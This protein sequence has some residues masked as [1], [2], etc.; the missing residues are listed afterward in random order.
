MNKLLAIVLVFLIPCFFIFGQDTTQQSSESAA[1]QNTT[2]PEALQ[3]PDWVDEAIKHGITR[4]KVICK[5]K[6]GFLKTVLGTVDTP[7]IR[8]AKAANEAKRKMMTFTRKDVTKEMLESVVWVYFKWP[9]NEMDQPSAEHVVIKKIKSKDLKFVT[10]PLKVSKIDMTLTNALGAK[11]V[12]QSILASF[13]P[14]AIKVGFEFS[15]MFGAS[16]GGKY[17]KTWNIKI[18]KKMLKKLRL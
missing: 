17:K 12:R 18:S 8:V 2:E 14:S 7:F 3:L 4:G 5:L 6:H 10:Q 15:L 16:P 13:S 1:K 9:G 11:I